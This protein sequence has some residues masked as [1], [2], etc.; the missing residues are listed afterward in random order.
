MSDDVIRPRCYDCLTEDV[1]VK[2]IDEMGF[3]HWFCAADWAAE[4]EFSAR[5]REALGLCLEDME[6]SVAELAQLSRESLQAAQ[7]P[8]VKAGAPASGL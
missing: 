1:S 2:L 7:N 5:V 3:E 6:R 8:A 4:Q